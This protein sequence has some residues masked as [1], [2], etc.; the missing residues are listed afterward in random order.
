VNRRRTLLFGA[1]VSLVIFA[2]MTLLVRSAAP[3]RSGA[4]DAGSANDLDALVGVLFGDDVIAFEV[5]GI[6]LTAAMIGALVIARP[7]E[8]V[9]DED[10]YSHPTAEQ[11]AQT[12]RVSDPKHAVMTGPSTALEASK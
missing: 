12:D 10:R 8:A 4:S 11:V 1:F 9:A 6:L 3:W 5:L 7:M 2:V